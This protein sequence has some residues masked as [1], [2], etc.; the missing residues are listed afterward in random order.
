MREDQAAVDLLPLL[1]GCEGVVGLVGGRKAHAQEG[2]LT[3]REPDSGMEQ[4]QP[5][6]PV[7]NQF[8]R[9]VETTKGQEGGAPDEDGSRH[10]SR[11]GEESSADVIG[12]G[13]GKEVTETKGTSLF[14]KVHPGGIAQIGGWIA[15]EFFYLELELIGL[16]EVVVVEKGEPLAL[17]LSSGEVAAG[18]LALVG[19][20]ED[21]DGRAVTLGE[22]GSAVGGTVIV[23]EDLVGREGLVKNALQSLLEILHGV[24]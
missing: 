23:D 21:A 2:L 24:V 10:E 5:K 1:Q 16:P 9:R 11:V 19:A 14:I 13:H 3:S 6:I 18:G 12:R 22:V 20:A 17:G 4:A 15:G 8:Y 7:L